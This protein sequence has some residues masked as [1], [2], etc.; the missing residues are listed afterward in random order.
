MKHLAIEKG[1]YECDK[2]SECCCSGLTARSLLTIRLCALTVMA[3]TV[4]DKDS[5]GATAVVA[6]VDRDF[7]Y[8]ANAGDSRCVLCKS[9]DKDRT[10]SLH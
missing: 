10:G 1:F 3:Q 7:V 5:S 4:S 6:V 9:A 2:E 8:V